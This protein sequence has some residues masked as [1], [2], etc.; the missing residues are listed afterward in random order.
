MYNHKKAYR[1]YP[2]DGDEMRHPAEEVFLDETHHIFDRVFEDTN[3]RFVMRQDSSMAYNRH[4][5]TKYMDMFG[6]WIVAPLFVSWDH[7][8]SIRIMREKGNIFFIYGG[9]GSMQETLLAYFMHIVRCMMNGIQGY[10]YYIA[11]DSSGDPFKLPIYNGDMTL[12]YPGCKFGCEEPIP[13]IRLKAIRNAV[14]VA[15]L[16]NLSVGGMDE[17]RIKDA[18]YQKLGFDKSAW[19]NEKPH[20]YGNSPE[21]VY[22]EDYTRYFNEVK[23]KSPRETHRG[24]SPAVA[25]HVRNELLSIYEGSDFTWTSIPPDV[26]I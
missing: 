2:F 23:V 5:K 21:T 6:M 10:T 25:A 18:V 8:E 17:G 26:W 20:F 19:Y 11:Y 13:S 7:D 1:M 24:I 9:F 14:Q 15:D 22:D 12:F 4:L 3:V 16:Y